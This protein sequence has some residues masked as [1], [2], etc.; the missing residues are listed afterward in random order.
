MLRAGVVEY[1]SSLFFFSF[2]SNCDTS[3]KTK[4]G[5]KESEGSPK[6]IDCANS[7][8]RSSTSLEDS[9]Y[10][11]SFIRPVGFREPK[12]RIK[13]KGKREGGKSGPRV[14]SAAAAALYNKWF[15]SPSPE[16]Y[17]PYQISM[18]LPHPSFLPSP[19]HV[20]NANFLLDPT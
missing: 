13:K 4:T 2:S 20:N 9:N 16:G 1:L 3:N 15:S 18:P 10:F 8:A 19:R 5:K 7:M 12:K 11:T 6:V 17:V 14:D